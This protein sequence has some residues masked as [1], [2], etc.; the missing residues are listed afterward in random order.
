MSEEVKE[1]GAETTVKEPSKTDKF[2]EHLQKIIKDTTGN[3]VSKQTAWD[4][5]KNLIAGTV[6]FVEN[7]PLEKAEAEEGAEEALGAR[8]LPL[9]GVGRFE[10]LNVKPRASKAG[11]KKNENGEWVRDESLKVWP[12][13]PRFRFRPSSKI[14]DRLEKVFGLADHEDVKIEHYGLF[15]TEEAP[16]P[17]AEAPAPAADVQ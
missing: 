3:K 8:T 17:A 12:F 1:T 6:E 9:A 11:L 2:K 4:L 14:S 10:I 7:Q 5:F 16:A 13:V 15:K